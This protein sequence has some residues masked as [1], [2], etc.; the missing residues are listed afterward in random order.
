MQRREWNHLT[1]HTTGPNRRRTATLPLAFR[2]SVL[3]SAAVLRLV[4]F[5]PALGSL[6]NAANAR[7]NRRTQ[8]AH[9]ILSWSADRLVRAQYGFATD[10]CWQA[11]HG[12]TPRAIVVL[13]LEQGVHHLHRLGSLV[14]HLFTWL[15]CLP[16]AWGLRPI[17]CSAAIR[18][19][20]IHWDF[21]LNLPSERPRARASAIFLARRS[22]PSISRSSQ[23]KKEPGGFSVIHSGL[24]NHHISRTPPLRGGSGYPER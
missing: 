5:P 4:R 8:V 13:D 15:F 21:I 9:R 20:C 2:I 18:H 1:S 6:R 24:P 16:I 7:S 10:L 14:G 12:G 17:S 19:C 23:Y 11:H 22:T 3:H